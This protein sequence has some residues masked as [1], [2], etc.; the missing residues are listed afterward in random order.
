MTAANELVTLYVKGALL[1][2]YMLLLLTPKPGL[3]LIVAKEPNTP[4]TEFLQSCRP[5]ASVT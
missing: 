3:V 2:L 5:A 4:T 1:P